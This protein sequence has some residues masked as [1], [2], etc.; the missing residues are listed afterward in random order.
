MITNEKGF[1]LSVLVITIA[2]MLILTM[3]A[4]VTL[5]NLTGDRE[6]TNFM[7]DLQEVEQFVKEYYAQKGVIPIDY[8]EN[9]MPIVVDLPAEAQ[10]QVSDDDVGNYYRIDLSKLGSIILA[11]DSRVYSVNEGTLK[12]Y[13]SRPITYNG[14][15]YYTLTDEM[16][17]IN[18]IYGTGEE[19]E[20]VINGNPLTW[21]T[22]SKLMVAVPNVGNVDSNWTFKYYKGGPITAKQFSS[23]GEFFEYG[24]VIQVTE[25]GIYSVYIESDTG[26]SK[27]VNVVVDKIDD[28]KPYVY[29]TIDNKIAI[30]DDETGISKVMYKIAD[31]SIP[32]NERTEDPQ[33]YM[34]GTES[35]LPDA[36]QTG[37]WTFEEAYTGEKID[38]VIASVGRSINTYKS[39]YEEYLEIYNE[40]QSL[41]FDLK[42]LDDAYPQFQHDGIPYGDDEENI[43]LYV[44][45]YAENRSVTDRNGM[46]HKVSRKMLLESNF[47]DTIIKPLN[48]AKVTIN[49]D[50]EYSNKRL[51]DLEIRAQ[52]AE[53]MFITEDPNKMPEDGDWIAF[54][55]VVEDYE[56]SDTNGE[57]E[58][59]VFVTAN[60]DDD[61]GNL[62][63]AK[64]SDKIFL[65][66]VKPT[67][68]PPELEEMSY[69]LKL[70]VHNKQE[71]KE[72]GIEKIEYGIRKEG[73][74]NYTWSNRIRDAVLESEKIYYVRT[75]VTDKAG[76]ISE[77]EVVEFKT[78]AALTRTLPN[79]PALATG[80]EAIIWDGTLLRPEK[81]IVINP[82]TWETEDGEKVTWYNYS[83]G[84]GIKDTKESIWAN[85]KTLDGSYWVWIPRYAYRIV[86]YTDSSKTEI[87]GYYQNSTADGITYFEADGKTIA[88]NPE[89]IKTNH[90]S[91]D[92]MFLSG[93]SSTQCREENLNNNEVSTRTL[94]P[95]YIVHPAFQR[96]ESSVVNNA[97]GKWTSEL[98]GIWVA[99]FEAS[100]S[101]ATI[102][103][104]GTSTTI[105]SVP[106]VLSATNL[107]ISEAYG[108]CTMMQPALY[109]HLMKSSEWGATVYLAHSA[110]GR[111]GFEISAN[112]N[113]DHI[114]GGG[115]SGTT[116]Y[117]C[118]PS[119]FINTYAYNVNG[120]DSK[121]GMHASTTGNIYGVYDL[122]GGVEE[123][124]ATYILNKHEN[125]SEYG[126]ALTDTVMPFMREA[127]TAADTDSHINNYNRNGLIEK[128]YGNAIYE[129]STGYVGNYSVASDKSVYPT[130]S[131]PFFIR[132]G[133]AT[134]STGAGSFSFDSATGEA[135]DDIG[136]RPVLAFR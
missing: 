38:E 29:K 123:F 12:V 33:T 44:E 42:R 18:R 102:E 20:V 48:G 54:S 130:G 134:S 119:K 69:D 115:S 30:G 14:I 101:D 114:T 49:E 45:D 131:E 87:K 117:T 103:E 84:N 3:T 82:S 96:I 19:F 71:D 37:R 73:D 28:I 81:E 17:G 59:F 98:T 9:D 91:V 135:S 121:A 90:L 99:K 126:E 92:V 116:A 75:R 5:K 4:I 86:Y 68:T 95:E 83:L 27:V 8:D 76:N 62:I 35:H 39:D 16:L 60:Q 46:M 89:D 78:P 72:S 118:T 52:G 124:V 112:R 41:N 107:E 67:T 43:V 110:Y 74:V 23:L 6:V 56:L 47:I 120:N 80:M 53:S 70:T 77:S 10:L 136:F 32:E 55:S 108:Y 113:S 94:P 13:V 2:V 1:S 93:T 34:Q 125:I 51:V 65:D 7:N 24:D 15:K 79:E 85:A 63:Y 11:D 133:S 100:R 106:S 61:E 105:K 22:G 129:T 31:Y 127:Y 25:N 132:G 36:A 66:T 40:Y 26:Y 104:V 122:A 111:N 57:V 109:S 50:A 64:V 97:S 128:V 88:E 21:S 58:L